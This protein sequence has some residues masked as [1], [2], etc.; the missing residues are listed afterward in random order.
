MLITEKTITS[1]IENFGIETNYIVKDSDHRGLTP[2][3]VALLKTTYFRKYSGGTVSVR[4][5]CLLV[6]EDVELYIPNLETMRF[7]L[8][9]KLDAD[10][11]ISLL[12]VDVFDAPLKQYWHKI[13]DPQYFPID[14]GRFCL[15]H[16]PRGTI[17]GA[18]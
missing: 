13:V 11:A 2:R 16:G 12:N 5:L 15:L 10:A 3:L 18:L 1:I 9:P 7:T 6:D 8:T 17:I 4:E 14:R